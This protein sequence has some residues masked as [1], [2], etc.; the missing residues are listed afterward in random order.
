MHPLLLSSTLPCRLGGSDHVPIERLEARIAPANFS[1]VF[2]SSM[3][4]SVYRPDIYLELVD[5][6]Q[7][8][9]ADAEIPSSAAGIGPILPT[10]QNTSVTL[11]PGVP[12]LVTGSGD[13]PLV[14]I[15][16]P[17]TGALEASFS[18]F[19]P[20]NDYGARVATADVNGDGVL[21]IIVGS[22][23]ASVGGARVRVFDGA[24]PNHAPLPGVLGDFKPFGAGFLGAI[25]VAAGDING[26]GYADIVVS[27]ASGSSGQVRVFSGI[28]SSLFGKFTAFSKVSGG[29]RVA[30]GD[31]D[32]D[33]R[34]EIV[35]GSG[36]GSS[37]RV[38]DW[39]GGSIVGGEAFQAFSSSYKGGVTVGAGDLDGDGVDEIVVGTASGAN[40]VRIFN[41]ALVQISEFQAASFKGVRLAV[42]DVNADGFA[43]IITAKG[44]GE[45]SAV[46]VFNG[47]TLT[48]LFDLSGYDLAGTN[49]SF[50]A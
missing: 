47:H 50:V 17:T 9:S 44:P 49:G 28:N 5:G 36:I 31:T 32:G 37:V 20:Q 18:A 35:V 6:A 40:L 7:R 23:R 8:A 39:I 38:F 10:A 1:A 27:P 12:F 22:G 30:T 16:D 4:M 33:G 13:G 34:A 19:G 41:Q 3:S 46:R 24:D 21:D 29:V 42:A 2:A 45:N 48:K 15:F 25:N 11:T 43:D 14:Q 26:D